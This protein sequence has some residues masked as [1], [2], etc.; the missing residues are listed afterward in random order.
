MGEISTDPI[1]ISG[2]LRGSAPS[3][4]WVLPIGPMLPQERNAHSEQNRK[5]KI[6]ETPKEDSVERSQCLWERNGIQGA[7][8]FTAFY[9]RAGP[10][11]Y[12]PSYWFKKKKPED[13]VWDKLS[14]L[15]SWALG[16][17]TPSVGKPPIRT[18]HMWSQD[19]TLA[20]PSKGKKHCSVCSWGPGALSQQFQITPAT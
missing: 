14:L 8:V 5:E 12:P 16:A 19:T 6:Q 20:K 10:H 17:K 9:L 2:K 4:S 13:R 18:N 7:P 3:N 1:D 15:A 11:F